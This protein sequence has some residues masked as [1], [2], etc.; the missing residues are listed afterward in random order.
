MPTI[1]EVQRWP[2][3][4]VVDSDGEKVGKLD[5]VYQDRETGEPSFG[6]A[7]TGLFG[8]SLSLVPI[9]SASLS[10]EDVR[11]PFDKEQ[12]KTAPKLEADA[13]LTEQEEQKLYEHYGLTHSAYEGRDFDHDAAAASAT[14]I[15]YA[16]TRTRDDVSNAGHRDVDLALA[17][18][19]TARTCDRSTSSDESCMPNSRALASRS[20]LGSWAK[21]S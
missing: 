12:V 17:R 6:A 19:L 2:G 5:H 21:T 9:E 14:G 20:A 16:G 18:I 7:K 4:N 8:N 10:G 13:E 11:I 1:E 3:A 15:G